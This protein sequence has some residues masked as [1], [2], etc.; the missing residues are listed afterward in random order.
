M[1]IS[2]VCI[3][4]V[5][6]PICYCCIALQ[7]NYWKLRQISHVYPAIV[8]YRNFCLNW[9]ISIVLFKNLLQF[10]CSCAL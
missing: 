8:L 6:V 2:F 3:Y 4:F 1:M 9:N 10:N 7:K 5:F